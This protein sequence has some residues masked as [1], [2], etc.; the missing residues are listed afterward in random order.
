MVDP[1]ER[2]Q[3]PAASI[4]GASRARRPGSHLDLLSRSLRDPRIPQCQ[5][6]LQKTLPPFADVAA[7]ES[8]LFIPT[9]EPN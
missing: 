3:T 8:L 1:P 7:I 6:S 5:A 9:K 4:Q 2:S